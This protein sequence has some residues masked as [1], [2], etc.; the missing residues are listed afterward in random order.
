MIRDNRTTR[1]AAGYGLIDPEL[2]GHE[3][4]SDGMGG[5]P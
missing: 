4:P 3:R 2:L 5:P 1:I